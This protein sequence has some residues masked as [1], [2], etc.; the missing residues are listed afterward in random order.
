[1]LVVFLAACASANA[2]PSSGERTQRDVITEAEIAKMPERNAY[3]LI[4]TLRPSMLVLRGPTSIKNPGKGIAVFLDDQKFS[5]D[6]AAL[7]NLPA[8]NIHEIRFVNAGSA[9]AR[10]GPGYPSGVILVTSKGR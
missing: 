2:R 3:E 7:K 4:Q 8:A 10:W 5:D 9:Q 6:V 1:M